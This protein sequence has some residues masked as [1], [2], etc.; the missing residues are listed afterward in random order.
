MD[1]NHFFNRMLKL[2]LMSSFTFKDVVFWDVTKRGPCKNLRFGGTYRL[3]LRSLWYL[4]DPRCATS[5][6]TT[7]FI[8][9]AVKTSGST[10]LHLFACESLMHNKLSGKHTQEGAEKTHGL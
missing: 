9:A 5:R 4:Q 2:I 6:K 1:A 3:H 8:A 10:V 7:F